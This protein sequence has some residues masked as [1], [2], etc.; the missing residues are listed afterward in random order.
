MSPAASKPSVV[1]IGGTGGI[2]FAI[3]K[4]YADRGG[5][6]VITGR[7]L[8]RTQAT[9]AQIGSSVRGIALDVAEPETAERALADIEHVD[10]LALV[11]VE[12]DYN[13][14]R[15]YDIAR[16]RRI[17]TMKLIGYTEVAHTLYP[18]MGAGASAVLFGGLASERPY[19]GSTSITTVNGAVSSLIRTLA[20]ELAP[21]RFN[22]IHPGII[23]DS[24]AWR[25]KKEAIV[26]IE[27][28]TPGGRLATTEDVVGAVDFLFVN[29]GVNGINLVIDGGWLLT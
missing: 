20:V 29:R 15:D 13:S 22:A 24:P 5:K 26:N 8:Q 11:A 3:A 21:V 19:P 10:H 18:R 27:K 14:A 4:F 28:R 2:G 6:V 7:D 23:S 17:V 16:A 1:V 9:A 12:R 25:D